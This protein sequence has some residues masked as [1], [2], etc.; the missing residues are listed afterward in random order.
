MDIRRLGVQRKMKLTLEQVADLQDRLHKGGR[1]L[2]S[3][4]KDRQQ[5]QNE[6]GA[7]MDETIL[8]GIL[9]RYSGAWTKLADL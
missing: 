6:I 1:H 2:E 3:R 8:D 5:V 9:S 4:K 7:F